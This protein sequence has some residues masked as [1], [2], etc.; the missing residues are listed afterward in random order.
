MKATKADS[1]L[2]LLWHRAIKKLKLVTN[3]LKA[4]D[5]NRNSIMGNR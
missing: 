2:I 4:D 1:T 5:I 3:E